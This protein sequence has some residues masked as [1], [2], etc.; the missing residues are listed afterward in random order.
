MSR[1]VQAIAG[2][3]CPQRHALPP[4][5]SA[6]LAANQRSQ[7]YGGKNYKDGRVEFRE[8]IKEISLEDGERERERERVERLTDRPTGRQTDR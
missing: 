6:L 5:S 3:P 1:A 2:R 8:R 4:H 7:P